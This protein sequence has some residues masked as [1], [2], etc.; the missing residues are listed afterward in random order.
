M[1]YERWICYQIDMVLSLDSKPFWKRIV[2]CTKGNLPLHAIDFV[3]QII[4][5][6]PSNTVPTLHILLLRFVHLGN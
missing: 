4:A 1:V 5:L 3:F 2:L 6:K